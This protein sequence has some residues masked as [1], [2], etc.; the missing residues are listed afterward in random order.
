MN[1]DEMSFVRVSPRDPR[2]FELS[3][4]KPYITIGFDLVEPPRPDELDS[5]IQKM[6]Q[7]RI[8]YC[9]VWLGYRTWT[10]EHQKSGEYDD[11]RG[12]F[13][14]RFVK[15][16]GD[17]GIRVKACLEYF[18]DIPAEDTGYYFIKMLHHKSQ[19]GPFDS[20]DDFLSSEKGRQQFKRKLAWYADRFGDEP[21]IFAWELWNEMDC[22]KGDWLPWTKVMLSELHRLFPKNLATQSL[23]SFDRENCRSDYEAAST[24]PEND[25]AQ[26]HRYLDLGAQLQVCHGPVDV[27]TSDAVRE[28]AEFKPNKPI[29]L[30]ETGAV[31][32]SHTGCS[33]L[34]AEDKD[35]MLLHDILF[36]PFF[37]GAAGTGHA[38]FWRQGIQKPDFWYHFVRFANAVEGIDPPAE[39][40]TP[41]MIPHQRLRI[42]ALSGAHT[43]IAWCRD[44]GNDWQTELQQGIPPESLNDVSLDLSA[45]LGAV[46]SEVAHVYDPWKDVWTECKLKDGKV[47]LPDFSRS[48]VIKVK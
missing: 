47:I 4:G 30:A 42:Y 38:W 13:I 16:A 12:D 35:G 14:Q 48:I 40:F 29:I 31:K 3:N 9:R 21:A 26:V 33:E 11:E 22:V 36:A 19:G 32:P 41:I 2:Y 6:A 10:V 23:G 24:L 28:I 27:L 8:N 1:K 39:G 25:V 44:A 5:V 37:A 15:L 7:N 43:F 18:R 46:K 17:N 45:Y 20:M 34:Y